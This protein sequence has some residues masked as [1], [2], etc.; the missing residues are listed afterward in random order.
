MANK[1]VLVGMSGGIDSTATCLMLQEQGYEVVGVTM[2]VWGEE[3]KDAKELAAQMGI[4]HYVADERIPFKETIVKYFIEEYKRGRTPNPCVMCNPLFKFRVL[5]EWADKLGCD[6]IATGHYSRLEEH[7]G[8]HYIVAGEDDKKDQSYFLWRLGQEVLKRCIFPLGTYTKLQVREYLHQKGYEAKSA[9][10]ESMEVCFIPG[11]YRD[12]LR[13]Q[14]P[15]LDKE[16]GPGWFVNSEGVKLGQHKGAPYYTI[17]QRKG[18]EIAL[19]KPAYVLKINAEKNTVMLGDAGQLQAEYMLAEQDC[20]VDEKE[21][22]ACEHLTV[23]IR[24]RSRPIPCRVKRLADGRLLVYFLAEASAI[25]PGQS[26]VFYDGRRVLGGAFIASQRG[27]GLVIQE[28]GF[29]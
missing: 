3:P 2:R 16:I 1:R 15:G 28:N 23:R 17:G 27:L 8:N 12:F 24:Y 11:D 13:E 5:T 22:F 6:W 4:E 14:C 29:V 25:A 7:N 18:L 20:I 21:L 10:G 19:G 9:E 26:A